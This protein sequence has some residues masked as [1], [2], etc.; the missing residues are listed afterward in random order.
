MPFKC[1]CGNYYCNLHRCSN[2]H[3]CTFDYLLENKEKI[4]KNNKRVIA[5]KF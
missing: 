5:N 3:N 4:K 1:K 2:E